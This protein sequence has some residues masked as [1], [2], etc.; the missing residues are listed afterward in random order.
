VARQLGAEV[1]VLGPLIE[2]PGFWSGIPT[3]RPQSTQLDWSEIAVVLHP[4]LFE[5][6]PTLHREAVRRGVPVIA[7]RAAGLQPGTFIEVQFGDVAAI[8]SATR[9]LTHD[10]RAT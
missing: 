3:R 9:A 2:G 1:I 10:L 7:T 8:E 6:S 5:A 4:T